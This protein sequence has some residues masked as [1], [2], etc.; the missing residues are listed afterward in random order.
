MCQLDLLPPTSRPPTQ[1]SQRLAGWKLRSPKKSLRIGSER[2]W[3]LQSRRA[4]RANPRHVKGL[5]PSLA[6][7]RRKDG[8]K[9]TF[10]FFFF[11]LSFFAGASVLRR[12]R[13][14]RWSSAA[15]SS[16]STGAAAAA[17]TSSVLEGAGG[18]V[19]SVGVASARAASQS[20]SSSAVG[21]FVFFFF[22]M[23]HGV[24]CEH[25][26]MGGRGD[27]GSGMWPGEASRV[28]RVR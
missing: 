26:G 9:L 28:L 6:L 11:L 22:P 2:P 17:A 4:P 10:F 27:W 20:S 25:E 16:F 15:V 8:P 5:C 7:A 14:W 18:G 13:D 12:P 24:A 1:P 3:G 21:A 23:L 19:A